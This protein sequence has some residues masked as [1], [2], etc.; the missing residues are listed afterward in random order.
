MEVDRALVFP[1]SFINNYS[2]KGGIGALTSM[3]S[4]SSSGVGYGGAGGNKNDYEKNSDD[5][6]RSVC[7]FL[8]YTV[9]VNTLFYKAPQVY[10]IVH[11]GS[12]LGVSLTSVVL[13]WI[14]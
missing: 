3:G 9:V 2:I 10:A 13:E 1:D 4:S 8:S 5:L 11:S 12:S 6:L 14:A 7:T